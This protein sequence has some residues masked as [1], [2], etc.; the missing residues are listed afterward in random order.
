MRQI[1]RRHLDCSLGE[2]ILI[3]NVSLVLFEQFCSLG[4]RLT[5][6][7]DFPSWGGKSPAGSYPGSSYS[8]TGHSR[9]CVR[10][11]SSTSPPSRPG[12][13]SDLGTLSSSQSAAEWSTLIG[14]DPSRYCALIGRD[15]NVANATPSDLSHKDRAQ[16]SFTLPAFFTFVQYLQLITQSGTQPDNSCRCHEDPVT[17]PLQE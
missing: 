13:S 8:S 5:Y 9:S 1:L 6:W 12:P 17:P 15:Y 4:P 16:M 2:R 11:Q 7:G 14:Q 3:S 10:S